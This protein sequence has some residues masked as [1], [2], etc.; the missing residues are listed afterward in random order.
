MSKAMLVM[1][2]PIDC[3]DCIFSV[4]IKGSKKLG[5]CLKTKKIFDDWAKV[6]GW[7]P[8]LEFPD[9]GKGML[10]MDIPE[11]CRLC[12]CSNTETT[13]CKCLDKRIEKPN[14]KPDWCRIREIPEE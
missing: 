6:Q 14:G 1:D 11:N 10:V 9:N 3:A 8:L 5:R 4:I 2:M 13:W 12:P 7:C